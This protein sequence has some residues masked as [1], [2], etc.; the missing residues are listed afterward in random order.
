M[1]PRRIV[2][3]TYGSLGDLHPYLAL[4]QELKARGHQ[5]LIATSELYR[6]RVTAQGIDFHAIRPDLPAPEDSAPIIERVMHPIH[7]PEYLFRDLLMPHLRHTYEDSLVAARDADLII[8]HPITFAAP[9]VA[10]KLHKPWLSTVLSPISLWSLHDPPVPPSLPISRALP[11]LPQPI[12]KA[13]WQLARIITRRWLRPVAQLRRELNLPSGQHPLFEGSHSPHGVLALFSSALAKPQTDW[14]ARTSLCGF[15]F[16]DRHHQSTLGH[17]LAPQ[18]ERFLNDGEAP[19]VFT[20]GSAA[21]YAARDFF[22][23]SALAARRLKRRAVF[24]VGEGVHLDFPTSRYECVLPYA[25]YSLLFPRAA[26]VVH[27]GGI[28]TTAQ[29]LHAGIPQLVVPFSHDQPD[30]AARIARLGCGRS[31]PRT[32]YTTQRATSALHDLLKNTDYATNAKRIA[33]QVRNE[34]GPQSACD[35]IQST[36]DAL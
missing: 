26:V 12:N 22:H 9:I 29:A 35:I 17:P 36:L 1:H 28:G 33:A 14:P 8:S 20:L 23:A 4:A 34:N 32:R 24:L 10:Q 18:L 6:E 19:I 31:L 2:L 25:P 7:G 5:P 21:V 30:N 27:Q 15:C 16:Y 11:Q 3:T 13:L